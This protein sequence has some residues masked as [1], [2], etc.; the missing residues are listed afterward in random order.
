LTESLLPVILGPQPA[1]QVVL[2]F[3]TGSGKI[4]V[5]IIGAATT[6]ARTTILVLL[7]PWSV[8]GCLNASQF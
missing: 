3:G 8:I 6:D 5:V 1:E 2:V 7:I 4:L